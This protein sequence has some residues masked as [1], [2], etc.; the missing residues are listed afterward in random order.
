MECGVQR[1]ASWLQH[2]TLMDIFTTASND[3]F[4][5]EGQGR[6]GHRKKG[7]GRVRKIIVG[8]GREVQG[9]EGTVNAI[10][11]KVG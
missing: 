8:K 4:P 3:V 6:A 2:T 1:L 5:G 7:Q 10:K 9:R 11:G